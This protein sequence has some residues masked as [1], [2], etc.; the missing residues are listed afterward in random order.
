MPRRASSALGSRRLRSFAARPVGVARE[1]Q[2]FEP[3]SV[4]SNKL[5]LIL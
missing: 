2:H 5:L 4:F 3:I 1:A